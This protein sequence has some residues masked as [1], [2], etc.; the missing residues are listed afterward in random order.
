MISG[1]TRLAAVIGWPVEHSRSPAIHNAAYEATG[2]D[3][4]YVALPVRPGDG[5]RALDSAAT[6][7][8]AGMNVTMPHK[9]DVA[10]AC[11]TLSPAAA[12]LGS[13]NTVVFGPD[14]TT[15]GH[16]TDGEGFLRSLADEGV[17]PRGR[18]VMVLGAGGA[19]HAVA[20]ALVAAGA[21]VEVAAR[22]HPAA[23]ALAAAV[24]GVAPARWPTG[25]ADVDIV[26]N[27]TPIGMGSDATIPVPAAPDQWIVD[28]VYHPL[29]T[30]W[31]AAAR[32]G[33]AHPVGGLGMLV[34]QAALAFELWTGVA[35][36]LEAMRAA[37][38]Q[39]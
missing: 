26:V 29:E 30:P 25:P 31:L 13:V 28:L 21:T 22:R 2:L 4:C 23:L 9:A 19:A 14:G 3:W 35:A 20:A 5:A 12:A 24:P 15:A 10:A 34:H 37:A 1:R 18:S 8:L 16:S 38:G 36:P 32:A 11:T 27:A 7:G 17:D 39:G 33:G 6:L